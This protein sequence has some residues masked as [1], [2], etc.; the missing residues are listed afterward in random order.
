MS[1]PNKQYL[2]EEAPVPRAVLSLAV[3][4]VI[5]TLVVVMYNMADTYFVGMLNDPLESAAVSISYPMMLSFYSVVHLFGT[6]SS[7]LMSRSL[8]ARDYETVRRASA[9]GVWGAVGA[10]LLISSICIFFRSSV[11]RS[12]GAD[13]T[14]EAAAGRYM[15]WTVACGAV[16]SILNV[17][18]SSMVRAEGEAVH[19]SIGTMLGCVLN[20]ILDPFF[21]LPRFLGMGAAGAGSATFISNCAACLYFF[22][23]CAKRRGETYVTISPLAWRPSKQLVWQTFAVG[24]PASIQNL[25]NVTGQVLLNNL[26]SPYGA[27]AMAAMGIAQKVELV[28]FQA[29]LGFAQG[30]MPLVGYNF[31]AGNGA[32]MKSAI[33]FTFSLM[34][35]LMTLIAVLSAV[36]SREVIAAFIKDP[37]VV[38]LGSAFL[39]TLAASIPLASCDFMTINVFQAI[40]KGQYSLAF[41]VMRKIILEIPAL[42][43]LNMLWPMYG[44][45][46]ARS[47]AEAVLAAA[48]LIMLRRIFRMA[49]GLSPCTDQS[50]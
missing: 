11:L 2:F 30:V 37:E 10:G 23:L 6:G 46:C 41:A 16:P 7:S 40:G 35:P 13:A 29:S 14:T 21:I 38:R 19:A 33:R 36:F 42:W 49:D 20:M 9:F 31:A 15:F 22:A 1:K 45:A 27:A 44:L 12:L 28:P 50:A 8:G 24:V 5:S 25:L 47:A 32:R 3:P 26:T 43:L 4:T 18:M 39:V 17:V 48:A 34:L